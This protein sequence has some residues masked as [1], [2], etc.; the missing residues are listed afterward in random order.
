MTLDQLCEFVKNQYDAG[1]H[2][3][4]Y[5]LASIQVRYQPSSP[6]WEVNAYNQNGHG[7]TL[8]EAIGAWRLQVLQQAQGHVEWGAKAWADSWASFQAL[9]EALA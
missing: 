5:P 2:P 1:T 4:P 9:Q 6:H 8:V 3:S 7:D